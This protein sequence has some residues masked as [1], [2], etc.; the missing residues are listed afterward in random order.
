LGSCDN[1]TSIDSAKL[2]SI[3]VLRRAGI[4]PYPYT[5][6]VTHHAKEIK[7]GFSDLEGR[8]VSIAGRAM[9]M[10]QMG[11]ITFIDIQD[12]TGRI[13]ALIR[14]N[15]LDQKSLLVLT[16]SSIGDTLGIRG[17][18]MKSKRGEISVGARE[19]TMLSKTLRTLPNKWQGLTDTETRY[20]SRHL[21][22]MMNQ[23]V[24]R[25]FEIRAKF[26]THVRSTLD[27]RG[28]IEVET[29]ILQDLYGGANA[30]PFTTTYHTLDDKLMFLRI[31]DELYLKRLIIGGAER[32]YEVSKDFRNEDADT[33]HN[34]EFTQIEYY[35]AYS[36]YEVFM[37]MMEDMLSSFTL[38]TF[39]SL[40]IEYRGETIDF[41]PP[42]KRMFWVDELKKMTGIDVSSMSDED[43]FTIND[44]EKL[45]L[46]H[47]DRYHVAD[48]LFDKYLKEK[49][50]Q[51]TFILDFPTY[52]CP[53]TKVKR[54]NPKLAERFELYAGR[55]EI[56]NSYSELTDPIY[57]RKMFEEQEK[58]R[59]K[60][61]EEAPPFDEEFIEA[62]EYGMPPTAGIGISIDR[63]AMIF[64]NQTSIKEVILFPPMK[65]LPQDD[66]GKR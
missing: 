5:Y 31:S 15:E 37:K 46:K 41:T 49:T 65:K 19:I 7:D 55:M 20:R 21:D 60:G 13:Q 56:A 51:P 14:N 40:K 24:L 44:S 17:V 63:P 52:M 66:S 61:D 33:T 11:G 43:A 62:I 1:I 23:E 39:G 8:D 4:E 42:F 18:V 32:V 27:M 12:R 54:G 3:N 2:E 59:N 22:L 50:F 10:R 35:E 9:Q 53:L 30:K 57:Q 48:S 64:T 45:A 38:K 28:A 29:P 16:N 34:P 36:D 47:P 6:S 58:E 25:T 26:M